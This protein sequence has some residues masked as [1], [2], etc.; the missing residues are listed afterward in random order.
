MITASAIVM[1]RRL[2]QHLLR[3]DQQRV[4]DLAA[5]IEQLRSGGVEF[6]RR[7]GSGHGPAREPARP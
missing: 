2:S 3:H 1:I 7:P 5:L 6:L 4:D